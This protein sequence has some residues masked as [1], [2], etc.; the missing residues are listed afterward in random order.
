VCGLILALTRASKRNGSFDSGIQVLL[1]S[2]IGETWSTT[3][4]P[5]MG[6]YPTQ[7]VES[8]IAAGRRRISGIP[9]HWCLI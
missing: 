8:A 5:N 1:I 4:P 2:E 9:P 6:E 7:V 3:T